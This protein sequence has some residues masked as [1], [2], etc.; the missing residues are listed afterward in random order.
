[1]QWLRSLATRTQR[2]GERD[3]TAAA[4]KTYVKTGSIVAGTSVSVEIAV[5]T[6]LWATWGGIAVTQE[7]AAHRAR[8][9]LARVHAAGGDWGVPSTAEL[10]TS[11]LAISASAFAI[12]RVG[13]TGVDRLAGTGPD[14]ERPTA[15]QAP[16]DLRAL[17]A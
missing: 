5:S 6:G 17:Q 1:M 11:L 16:P 10:E 15:G 3:A 8:A 2:G 14:M 9:E 7:D 13:Q 4:G 12:L